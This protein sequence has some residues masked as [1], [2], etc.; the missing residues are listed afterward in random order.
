M[1]FE[2]TACWLRA[3]RSDL[4]EPQAHRRMLGGRRGIFKSTFEP[5]SR[6]VNALDPVRFILGAKKKQL[7]PTV[8]N[9]N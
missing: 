7:S 9:N 3:S 4:A 6:T 8:I 5:K 1:G 2:P